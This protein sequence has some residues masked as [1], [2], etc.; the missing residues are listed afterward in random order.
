MIQ[1]DVFWAFAI[2]GSLAAAAYHSL[3]A[4]KKPLITVYF[5]A[6]LCYLSLLFNPSGSYLLWQHLGWETMWVYKSHKELAGILT[7]AF[8]LTNVLNGIIG[9]LA[10]LYVTKRSLWYGTLLWNSA[11]VAM[12]G[13]LGLG[14]ARFMYP[15]NVHDWVSGKQYALTDFFSSRIFFTLLIMG[16]FLLPPYFYMLLTWPKQHSTPA[17]YHHARLNAHLQTTALAVSVGAVAYVLYVV[18]FADAVEQ[19]R[20]SAGSFGPFAPLVGYL[21]AQFAFG[22][23]VALPLVVLAQQGSRK[24]SS[25][26]GS[27][28]NGTQDIDLH[29]ALPLAPHNVKPQRSVVVNGTSSGGDDALSPRRKTRRPQ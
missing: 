19:T 1:V 27:T 10:V 5:V 8:S 6:T 7:L 9:F 22:L 26:R 28:A 23:L 29:A 25:H 2:G 16:V 13:I 3:V 17:G 24:A 4:E 21:T 20:L 14:Y 11:Y 15:G 18:L 12:F